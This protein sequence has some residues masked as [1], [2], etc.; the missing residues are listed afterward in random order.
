M[1]AILFLTFW[2]GGAVLH[3]IFDF[4]IKPHIYN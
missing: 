2:L 4:K 1:E 3:T